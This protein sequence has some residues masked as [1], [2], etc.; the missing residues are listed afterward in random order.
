MEELYVSIIILSVSLV[1]FFILTLRKK[2]RVSK[3]EKIKTVKEI[4]EPEEEDSSYCTNATSEALSGNILG[5]VTTLIGAGIVIMVGY[6]VLGTL[7]DSLQDSVNVTDA[8]NI[9]PN[10]SGLMGIAG[11]VMVAIVIIIPVF[12]TLRK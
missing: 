9:I 1:I 7:Q 4:E 12:V 5:L 3:V 2:Y 8:I 11:I 10:V 6:L